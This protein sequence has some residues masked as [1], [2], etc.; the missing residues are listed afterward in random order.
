FFSFVK[1]FAEHFHAEKKQA[2]PKI[3]PFS[4]CL[5]SY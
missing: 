1:N 4:E 5:L 2:F 3:A